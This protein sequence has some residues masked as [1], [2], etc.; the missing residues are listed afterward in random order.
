MNVKDVR[1]DIFLS[2]FQRLIHNYYYFLWGK[3]SG[4]VG[5]C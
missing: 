5:E 2:E 3:R 4:G 1:L